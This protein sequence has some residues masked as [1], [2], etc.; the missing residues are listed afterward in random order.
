[1]L[2]LKNLIVLVFLLS[3]FNANAQDSQ[4]A[5]GVVDTLTSATFWG[6]GY[7]NNGMRKA[8]QYLS[9]QFAST[10]ILP[11]N[12]PSY[13]QTFSYPV[14]TF[15]GKMEVAI[16]GTQLQPGTQF[17]VGTESAGFKGEV[18]LEKKDST[19][20]INLKK[21]IIVEVKDK[22]TWSV[23]NVATDYTSIEVDKKAMPGEPSTIKLDVENKFISSFKVA[24]VTGYI[25]GTSHPD[26]FVVF[27][28]HY[29]HLGGMGAETYFPGANDNA[30]GISLLLGLAKHY[31]N[32]PPA[33]SVVFICFA[34]EEA[35]LL[36]SKYF[37]EHSL[38]PLKKIKFLTNVD[39]VGTGVEG[40]TVVNATEFA[41]EFEW[42]NQ[43]N[44]EQNLLVKIN[45]RGKAANSDHYWFTEKGV[46]AFFMY[47][48]GGIKAYHDVFDR[49]TTLPLNEYNDLFKLIVLFN[50]RLME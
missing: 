34:G 46:P 15:P 29:D 10:G 21:K 44:R 11:L 26:S 8:A 45:A 2:H 18:M 48:L 49:S 13:F 17:I 47:T 19:H 50:R 16:N 41:K 25:M 5:R 9:E 30:S 27:T 39:L 33:Y 20:F 24:N 1:M 23:S 35:G 37:T 32:N 4:Y 31:A 42:L 38:I 6:R 14:N 7:T 43:I 22:L 40:I 3:F 12:G 36:G 28:A